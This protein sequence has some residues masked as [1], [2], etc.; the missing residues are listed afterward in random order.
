MHTPNVNQRTLI[1]TFRFPY[2]IITIG[3]LLLVDTASPKKKKQKTTHTIVSRI[4]HEYRQSCTRQN[5]TILD[6]TQYVDINI[7][8]NEHPYAWFLS[9]S[10]S[11]PLS[12]PPLFRNWR[13]SVFANLSIWIHIH[14]CVTVRMCGGVTRSECLHASY[15]L[16]TLSL[17]H[18][19]DM[20]LFSVFPNQWG[21]KV[22][23]IGSR[24]SANR[25]NS[26]N[27]SVIQKQSMK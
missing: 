10:S 4:G 27:N 25:S 22:N 24:T 12:R 5:H 15:Q 2:G 13:E 14:V 21:H 18:S 17:I 19:V 9:P 23:H 6:Y 7:I 11:L 1:P 8:S 26:L 16:F 20:Y 3:L